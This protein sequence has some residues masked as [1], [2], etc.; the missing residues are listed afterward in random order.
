MRHLLFSFLSLTS[1]IRLSPP[2]SFPFQKKAERPAC[3]QETGF[4]CNSYPSFRHGVLPAAAAA[5]KKPRQS[6]SRDELF[7]GSTLIKGCCPSLYAH[8]ARL[9][10][11]L[12]VPRGPFRIY[13]PMILRKRNLPQTC[14]RMHFLF[15]GVRTASSAF[16]GPSLTPFPTRRPSN[17]PCIEK[18]T[19]SVLSI[20]LSV[21]DFLSFPYLTGYAKLWFLSIFFQVFDINYGNAILNSTLTC[22]KS[23]L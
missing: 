17:P 1:D 15:P 12:P 8:N 5:C 3:R 20:F 11:C 19:L 21:K 7:R 13:L 18:S 16:H 2:G 10:V 6:V 4:R 22:G 23:L 14:S 9:R